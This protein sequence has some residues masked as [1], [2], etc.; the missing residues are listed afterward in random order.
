MPYV[1][2]SCICRARPVLEV[3]VIIVYRH[4]LPVFHPAHSILFHSISPPLI[5]GNHGCQICSSITSWNIDWRTRI[6]NPDEQKT[7]RFSTGNQLRTFKNVTRGPHIVLE[8]YLRIAG[9][10]LK[11]KDRGEKRKWG[12]T[13]K[14][15]TY[16]GHIKS[17]VTGA[18]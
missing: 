12:R 10:G 8:L 17:M 14:I 5:M 6:K 18:F 3:S 7:I 16:S 4:H 13:K 9:R 1:Q 15:P 2:I 11:R